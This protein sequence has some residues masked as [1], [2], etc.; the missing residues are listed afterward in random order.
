MGSFH[1]INVLSNRN[2]VVLATL[3]LELDHICRLSQ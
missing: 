2:S 1:G 3:A